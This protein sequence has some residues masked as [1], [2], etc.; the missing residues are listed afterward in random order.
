MTEGKSWST[1]GIR[2]SLLTDCL[3]F[4]CVI[5]FFTI[6]DSARSGRCNTSESEL[7][8]SIFRDVTD[9]NIF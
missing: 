4:V 8:L 6:R 7:P 1:Y 9:L 3:F 5:E 2:A